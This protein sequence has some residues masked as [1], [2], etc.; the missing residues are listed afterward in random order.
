M[1]ARPVPH[2][3]PRLSSLLL[4]L[5]LLHE[6]VARGSVLQQIIDGHPASYV[7][8]GVLE[9]ANTYQRFRTAISNRTKHGCERR[10]RRCSM[11]R[12][13]EEPVIAHVCQLRSDL[14]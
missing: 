13:N 11:L 2:S 7:L 10:V 8:D 12:V 6:L 14:H 3:A 5:V 4:V 9:A 1:E